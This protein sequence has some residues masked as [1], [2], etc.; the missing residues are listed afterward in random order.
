MKYQQQLYDNHAIHCTTTNGNYTTTITIDTEGTDINK[1][2][3]IRSDNIGI[4]PLVLASTAAALIK[5]ILKL[6]GSNSSNK[7]DRILDKE[8]IKLLSTLSFQQWLP[9]FD[10]SYNE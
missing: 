7:L 9:Y 2:K 5:E 3:K 6:G 1:S 4:V 8:Y 10:V